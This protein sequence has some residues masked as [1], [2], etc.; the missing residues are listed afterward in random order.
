MP[1]FHQLKNLFLTGTRTGDAS[2]PRGRRSVDN[3]DAQ[4][5]ASF[6]SQGEQANI[7][8]TP[9]YPPGYVKAYDEGRPRK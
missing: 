2:A 8:A 7:A 6:R 1:F 5:V 9:G 3:A 4:S